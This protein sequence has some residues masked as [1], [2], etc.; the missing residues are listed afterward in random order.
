ME[1]SDKVHSKEDIL[2]QVWQDKVV[3][4]QAVFQNISHLRNLFGNEAIKTFSKRGYQWQLPF[5]TI[6]APEIAN[7]EKQ[8]PAVT[9]TPATQSTHEKQN[10]NFGYFVALAFMLFI[11]LKWQFEPQAIEA[12]QKSEIKVAYLPFADNTTSEKSDSTEV[13]SFVKDNQY[14]D[15]VELKDI[16]LGKYKTSI[17]LEYP[18]LAKQYPYVISGQLREYQELVHLDFSLQAPNI[19]WSGQ[20]SA[21]TKEQ[22]IN[23]LTEHLNKPIV[24]NMLTSP[25][26]PDNKQAALSLAHQQDEQDLIILNQ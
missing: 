15:F 21:N 4:E 16:D 23:L 26:T 14:F 18:S 12:T 6:D 25:L 7:V 24:E 3:S 5:N 20:L 17:E 10:S 19:E 8:K 2:S 13:I 9:K 22:V 11:F 1:Q